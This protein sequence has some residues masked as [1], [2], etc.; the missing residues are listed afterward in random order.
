MA[1][2][3]TEYVKSKPFCVVDVLSINYCSSK[4]SSCGVPEIDGRVIYVLFCGFGVL[5]II[6][7][8]FLLQPL[9]GNLVRLSDGFC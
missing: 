3:Y 6:L 1:V 8:R 7:W 5:M 9:P 4:L 2:Q